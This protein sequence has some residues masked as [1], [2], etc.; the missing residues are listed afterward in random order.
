MAGCA[1]SGAAVDS[2]WAVLFAEAGGEPVCVM[3]TDM[4]SYDIHPGMQRVEVNGREF[5]TATDDEIAVVVWA[6]HPTGVICAVMAEATC[7]NSPTEPRT[8]SRESNLCRGQ[9]PG[10][11]M[12]VGSDPGPR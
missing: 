6:W 12:T 1:L 10:H 7:C 2:I 4:G 3:V 9:T 8:R 11:E 5:W